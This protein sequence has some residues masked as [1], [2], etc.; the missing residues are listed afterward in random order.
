MDQRLYNSAKSRHILHFK[1]LLNE[2][3]NLLLKLRP[4]ENS[5]L[6]IAARR[7][8]KNIIAEIYNQQQCLLTQ[9]NLDRDTPLH[10]VARADCISVGNTVLH[11]AVRS[12]GIRVAKFLI[13]V[14]PGMAYLE[15]N[16]GESPL[17]LAARDGMVKL[18]N[19]ILMKA[20]SSTYGGPD[21]QTAL[22]AAIAESH[23]DVTE[24]LVK[25]EP[26]LIKETDHHG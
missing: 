3:P 1:Q 5:P 17:Y 16:T 26:Q 21:G 14:D 23:F 10:V 7:G 18:M 9:P 25:V 15:N 6:H 20:R 19:H 4:R 22:H 24:A 2:N 8:H 12:H 13:K 11:K